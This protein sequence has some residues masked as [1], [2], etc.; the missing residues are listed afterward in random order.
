[1][2]IR[3]FDLGL[4]K[5]EE[6]H[7]MK[8]FLPTIT[9]DY[10]IY[11]F[12]AA[13]THFNNYCKMF[14]DTKTKVYNVAISS[15]HKSNIKLYY[16][17]NKVG[18]SI[19][20]SKQ[21]I[22]KDKF[23]NVPTIKFTEWL[24]DN[25]INL[26]D[27]FNIIKINIEGAEWEF[28]NDIISSNLNK[29]IDIYCGAGHDVEKIKNFVEN[30]IVDKYYKLLKDNDIILHRWVLSWKIHKNI[31]LHKMIKDKLQ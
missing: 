17:H 10:E 7:D 5:G 18:H 20:S 28:F 24:K 25:N 16:A 26:K 15:E 13:P 14:S 3:Y 1:M 31:D 6:L 9:N 21:N 23:W 27:S 30:G 4:H 2:K 19:H 12:E 29:Y 11:G 8:K 22:T